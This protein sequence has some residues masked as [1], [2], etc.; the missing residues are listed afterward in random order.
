MDGFTPMTK[1]P[2]PETN[3]SRAENAGQDLKSRASSN[4]ATKL[5]WFAL[6]LQ[7]L[8]RYTSL[9]FFG[10]CFADTDANANANT[11]VNAEAATDNNFAAAASCV[12]ACQKKKM[13]GMT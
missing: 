11:N 7:N 10:Y 3:S 9:M 1:K 4:R 8:A 2:Q 5:L 6:P 13:S 12:V